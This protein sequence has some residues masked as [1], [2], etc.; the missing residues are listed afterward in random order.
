MAGRF[1]G[2]FVIIIRDF[3]FH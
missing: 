2:Y 3:P 1:T